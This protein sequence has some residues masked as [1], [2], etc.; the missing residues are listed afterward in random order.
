MLLGHAGIVVFNTLWWRTVWRVAEAWMRVWEKNLA[1][2]WPDWQGK[3]F[4]RVL[5]CEQ[6]KGEEEGNEWKTR[7]RE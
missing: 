2:N 3:D 1:E 4:C 6:E 5:D 7:A